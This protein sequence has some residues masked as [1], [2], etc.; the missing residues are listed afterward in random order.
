MPS[1][2][3]FTAPYDPVSS[4][5]LL[6]WLVLFYISWTLFEIPHLA[7]GSDLAG[8]SQDKNRV[9]SL[10]ALGT[11]LGTLLF[12]AIPLLPIFDSQGYTPHTLAWAVLISAILMVPS[13]Y[14][15]F[16]LIPDR[17]VKC[18]LSGYSIDRDALI[19]RNDMGLRRLIVVTTS[20]KPFLVFVATFF[21]AGF[22]GGMS[23]GLTYIFAESYLGIGEYLPNIYLLS[24]GIAMVSIAGWHWLA[25][26]FGK[27]LSWGMGMVGM[28]VSFLSLALLAPGEDSWLNLLFLQ[29]IIYT[30]STAAVVFPPAIL[31][32]IIDYGHWKFRQDYSGIYYSLY[33]F[34][35]KLSL[36]GGSAFGLAIAGIYGFDAAS[37]KHSPEHIFGLQ[38]GL[39]YIPAL[40]LL[41]SLVLVA[42]API[43][44]RRQKIIRARLDS[45]VVR[46][47]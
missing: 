19:Q 16:Q 40:M 42:V 10:R 30:C 26:V 34:I 3:N 14:F 43:T 47:K 23:M 17:N 5:Y 15:S 18:Q 12:L 45:R 13:L 38:L 6:S 33:T 20:N 32:S 44:E 24:I 27:T 1:G 46:Y 11:Y 36:A 25:A 29:V 31:S 21:F 22:G 2:H 28:S 39:A 7:W 41:V 37:S 4:L 35:I 8:S 9:F